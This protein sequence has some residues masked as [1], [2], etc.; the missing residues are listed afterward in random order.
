MLSACDLP[1][2]FTVLGLQGMFTVLP[3]NARGYGSTGN[4]SHPEITHLSDGTTV[5]PTEWVTPWVTHGPTAGLPHRLFEITGGPQPQF[6]PPYQRWASK[7][8]Q[9]LFQVYE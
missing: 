6:T 8:C 5:T 9:R 2:T 3:S 7:C 1:V 4:Y